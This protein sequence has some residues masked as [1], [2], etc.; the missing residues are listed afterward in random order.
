MSSEP[1]KVLLD[2]LPD[3]QEMGLAGKPLTKVS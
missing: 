2:A 1:I 3:R